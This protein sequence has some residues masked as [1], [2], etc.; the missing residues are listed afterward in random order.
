MEETASIGKTE[1]AKSRGRVLS[2]H[3]SNTKA[4]DHSFNNHESVDVRFKILQVYY[5]HSFLLAVLS[6]LPF[7]FQHSLNASICN[8]GQ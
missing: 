8:V 5:P 2:F 3:D 1:R 7:L 6:S 4:A